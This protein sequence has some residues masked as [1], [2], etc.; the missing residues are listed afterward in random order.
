MCV[1]VL[2][3]KTV[4]SGLAEHN[5]IGQTCTRGE[6]FVIYYRAKKM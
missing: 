4:A 6:C 3:K 2:V 5:R 1:C